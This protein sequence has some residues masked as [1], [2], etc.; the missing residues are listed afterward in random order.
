MVAKKSFQSIEEVTLDKMVS[1]SYGRLDSHSKRRRW[2]GKDMENPKP[3]QKDSSLLWL[4]WYMWKDKPYF[5][6]KFWVGIFLRAVDREVLLQIVDG[7]RHSRGEEPRLQPGT[8]LP[9]HLQSRNVRLTLLISF[10]LKHNF[11]INC[12]LGNANQIA[13]KMC[14]LAESMDLP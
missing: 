6:L 4:E 10:I 7:S 2:G 9:T 5:S 8:T 13:V 3:Y 1:G 11:G 12:I 14:P